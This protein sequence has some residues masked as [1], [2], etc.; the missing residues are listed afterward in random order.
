MR[1][2]GSLPRSQMPATYPFP[3]PHPSS[4]SP[5]NPSKSSVQ[6]WGCLFRFIVDTFLRW[7]VVSPSP[8]PK[9]RETNN[10]HEVACQLTHFWTL[11][12]HEMNLCYWFHFHSNNKEWISMRI[13]V[14]FETNINFA[15]GREKWHKSNSN[16][17]QELKEKLEE[18]IASLLP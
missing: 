1:S 8:K 12:F 17:L 4:P 3:E 6:D 9:A 5:T 7:G 10:Q 13:D 14:T 2:E 11:K 18:I 15:P 16:I